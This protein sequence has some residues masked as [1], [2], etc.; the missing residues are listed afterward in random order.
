MDCS[1]NCLALFPFDSASIRSVCDSNSS[2]VLCSK[3]SSDSNSDAMDAASSSAARASCLA[4]SAECLDA[5]SSSNLDNASSCWLAANFSSP[6]VSA[7]APASF[8]EV[9]SAFSETDFSPDST[10]RD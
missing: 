8:R 2:A 7:S 6:T 9:L 4:A 10:E 3:C 5:S 1:I